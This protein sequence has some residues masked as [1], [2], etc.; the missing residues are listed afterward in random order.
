MFCLKGLKWSKYSTKGTI[1]S[2][3]TYTQQN[4][5]RSKP[6]KY[7]AKQKLLSGLFQMSSFVKAFLNPKN[8]C[9]IQILSEDANIKHNIFSK[10]VSFYIVIF[11]FQLILPSSSH[12]LNFVNNY[13][14]KICI[15]SAY[16]CYLVHLNSEKNQDSI[17]KLR[18]FSPM[19]FAFKF[20]G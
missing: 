2:N 3:A 5:V 9:Y 8:H 11:I 18:V 6:K 12:F 1:L 13:T 20:L 15:Q 10:H 16:R 17:M 7:I 4:D 14:Q 19:Y